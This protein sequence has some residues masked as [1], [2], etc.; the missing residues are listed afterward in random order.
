MVNAELL[1]DRAQ[2]LVRVGSCKN[3]TIST[4]KCV[5]PS[6]CST[7]QLK[8]RVP[9]QVSSTVYQIEDSYWNWT[10]QKWEETNSAETIQTETQSSER[11]I[12]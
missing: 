9:M 5:D 12:R 7:S 6:I 2:Y 1:Y 4:D 10:Q 11:W 3:L 8:I